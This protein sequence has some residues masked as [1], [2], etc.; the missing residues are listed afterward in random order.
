[1]HVTRSRCLPKVTLQF[2]SSEVPLSK[3]L[4][5]DTCFAFIRK[6]KNAHKRDNCCH[7]RAKSQCDSHTNS[8]N[9]LI[10][11]LFDEK[12]VSS[13]WHHWLFFFFL[14]WIGLM[15]FWTFYSSKCVAFFRKILCSTTSTFSLSSKSAY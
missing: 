4:T 11:H 9:N 6:H 13:C 12:Y 7:I 14:Q 8:D 3:L 1:M 15:F 2:Y 5:L 10:K